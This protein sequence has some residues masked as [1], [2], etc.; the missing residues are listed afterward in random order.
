MSV[1]LEYLCL[2]VEPAPLIFDSGG[3]WWWVTWSGGLICT[4]LAWVGGVA[5]LGLR[6]RLFCCR[7]LALPR[8]FIVPCREFVV[9]VGERALD[10]FAAGGGLVKVAEFRCPWVS[11]FVEKGGG[12]SWAWLGW[13]IL[14]GVGAWVCLSDVLPCFLITFL[15]EVRDIRSGRLARGGGTHSV[16]GGRGGRSWLRRRTSR[17]GRLGRV[18]FAVLQSIGA[19]WVCYA[20]LPCSIWLRGASHLLCG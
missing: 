11:L 5:F 8:A 19:R 3:L 9:S 15:D 6:G 18:R 17:V 10:S 4:R 16:L 2:F 12:R 13:L 7:G 1:F 14:H 20:V